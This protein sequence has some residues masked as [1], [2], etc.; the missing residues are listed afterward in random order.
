MVMLVSCY[1][2]FYSPYMPALAAYVVSPFVC[3]ALCFHLVLSVVMLSVLMSVPNTNIGSS[4][5]M[6]K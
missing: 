2:N 5:P 4:I 3:V 6:R 1:D